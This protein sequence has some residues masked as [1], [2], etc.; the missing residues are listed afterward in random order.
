MIKLCMN[1]TRCKFK[2]DRQ[3]SV[4]FEVKIR[5]RLEDGFSPVLFHIALDT[6]NK[7]TQKKNEG[8]NLE[9]N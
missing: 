8:V 4:E 7:Q 2:F 5:L 6:V 3:L 9:D 1:K